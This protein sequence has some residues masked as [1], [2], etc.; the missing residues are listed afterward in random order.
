MKS[1]GFQ[2]VEERNRAPE[3]TLNL[4][5]LDSVARAR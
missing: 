1:G 4:S 3:D 5:G 2:Y